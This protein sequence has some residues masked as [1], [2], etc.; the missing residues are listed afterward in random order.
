MRRFHGKHTSQADRDS[1]L[2]TPAKKPRGDDQSCGSSQSKPFEY[3]IWGS[4]KSKKAKVVTG[5]AKKVQKPGNPKRL[6]YEKAETCSVCELV[7]IPEGMPEPTEQTLKDGRKRVLKMLH[8]GSRCHFCHIKI[9]F[10]QRKY[11]VRSTSQAAF[12]E[13]QLGHIKAESAAYRAQVLGHH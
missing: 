10:F 13:M 8:H 1:V 5:R 9:Q 3:S 12:T 7:K 6:T 4:P 11:G 2:E